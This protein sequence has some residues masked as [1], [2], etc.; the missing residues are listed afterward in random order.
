[1]PELV[2]PSQPMR[3]VKAY[4]SQQLP[5]YWFRAWCCCCTLGRSHS[6]ACASSL[7]PCFPSQAPEVLR[8]NYGPECDIW[9]L[10]VVLYILLSGMP[11]FWG[12]E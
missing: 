8:R 4:Y 2:T 7:T 3:L 1:M 6:P 9:S 10:G 12:T 5:L 11:P